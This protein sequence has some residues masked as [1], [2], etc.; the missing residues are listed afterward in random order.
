VNIKPQ[1]NHSW[2][3]PETIN[4]LELLSSNFAHHCISAGKAEFSPEVVILPT[5]PF[6]SVKVS[7][8]D[9]T[10]TKVG[11]HVEMHSSLIRKFATRERFNHHS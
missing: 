8:L 4:L 11:C 7:E 6:L 5:F 1:D 9:G 10:G 3:L 2:K